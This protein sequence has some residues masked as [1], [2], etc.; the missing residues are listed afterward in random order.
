LRELCGGDRHGVAVA[1]LRK[2]PGVGPVTAMTFRTEVLRPERFRRGEQV[3]SYVG[4]APSVRR[5]GKTVH[6]GPITKAGSARLRTVLV[7]AAWQWIRYDP[8]AKKVFKR[9]VAATGNIQKAI[10][11]MARRLAIVLWR[12]LT[13]GEVYT[14]PLL[15][16][17]D[18]AE[19]PPEP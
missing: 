7:E 3:A 18:A 16:E 19:P 2:V 15:A 1:L 8:G 13:T 14:P 17:C 5:T 11:A 6:R 12:I 4:L 9:L 10:V